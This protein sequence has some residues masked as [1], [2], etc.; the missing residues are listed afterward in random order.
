MAA[1]A[2]LMKNSKDLL[3]ERLPEI[4]KKHGIKNKLAGPRIEKVALSMGVGRA[5]QDGQ[6]LNVATEHLSQIAGQ[7]AVV[8][9]SKKAVANFRT[10]IGVKIGCRVTLRGERMWSFLDKLINLAVPRIKD[11][12]GLNPKGFDGRGNY[13]M[14]LREQALFHE[15]TLEKLEHNQGLNITI[16]IKNSNDDISFDLLKALN[17]PFR[18]IKVETP[19]TTSSAPAGTPAADKPQQ[20]K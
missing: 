16:C 8:T 19:K 9:K 13:N 15:V 10:R 3:S 2:T 18:E 17:M 11:F 14:G 20:T 4:L 6:I 1:T 12:R 5:V 7:R